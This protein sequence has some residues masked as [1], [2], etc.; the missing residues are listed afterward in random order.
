MK[1]SSPVSIEGTVIKGHQVASGTNQNPLFPGGTLAMQLPSFQRLGLDLSSYHLATLN[2]SISPLNFNIIDP[3]WHFE[4][5]KWHPTEPAEN[6]SFVSTEVSSAPANDRV[7][8]LIYYPHPETKPTHHQP[9]GLLELLLKK[10][11]P[12]FHY[13]SKIWL[14]PA[15]D[16]IEFTGM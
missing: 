10:F 6:F 15:P 11:V 7:E 14:F 16:R 13:G 1:N 3:D 4:K 9:P 12:E 2:V 8:G 5:V